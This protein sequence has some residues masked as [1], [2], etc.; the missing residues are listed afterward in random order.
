MVIDYEINTTTVLHTSGYMDNCEYEIYQL[1]QLNYERL[2][3]RTGWCNPRKIPIPVK[4]IENRI[5]LQIRNQLHYKKCCIN[6]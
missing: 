1:Y 2:A 4:H 3:V 5:K 6:N